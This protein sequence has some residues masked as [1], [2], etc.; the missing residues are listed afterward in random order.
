MAKKPQDVR[1]DDNWGVGQMA[2]GSINIMTEDEA[3][4]ARAAR[5]AEDEAFSVEMTDEDLDDISD[6]DDDE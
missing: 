1:K 3:I 2:D 5:D 6:L 4:K